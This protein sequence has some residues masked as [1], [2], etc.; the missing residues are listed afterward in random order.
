MLILALGVERLLDGPA[1]A[2]SLAGFLLASAVVAASGA[3]L[4]LA[5]AVAADPVL[6]LGAG[7]RPEAGTP[8]GR[9]PRGV[10]SCS[11]KVP[12]EASGLLLWRCMRQL[13]LSMLAG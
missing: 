10:S 4:R 8:H 11:C 9:T 1:A 2:A 13:S 3:A 6:H 5:T 7:G 12:G